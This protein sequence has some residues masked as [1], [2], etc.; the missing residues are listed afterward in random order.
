MEILLFL[1]Q[2]LEQA[3]SIT[4]CAQVIARLDVA[5]SLGLIAYNRV[6]LLFVRMDSGHS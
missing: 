2:I 1:L 4:G 3:G 6:R 5:V